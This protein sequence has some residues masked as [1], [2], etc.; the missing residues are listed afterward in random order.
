MTCGEALLALLEVYGVDTVFGIPGIH[1]M[2]LYRGLAKSK[3]R[4]ITPRHEQGAG[5]MA[6]GYA[7]VTGTPGVCFIITGPGMTNIATAMAQAFSDSIP[8]LVV[9][10]VNKTHELSLGS[11][12]LHELPSQRSLTAQFTEFS[13]TLLDP[14]ELPGVLARAF[15]VFSSRRPAPVHIEIPIDVLESNTEVTLEAWASPSKPAPD[16]QTIRQAVELLSSAERPLAILGGGT[17]D[18]AQPSRE[19]AEK[20]DMPVINTVAAKGVV[21]ASHDLCL[22]AT[23]AFKPVRELIAEADVVLAVGTEFSET[24]RYG[25][26]RPLHMTADLIRIDIDPE[27]LAR[28]H[29]PAIALHSDANLALQALA[30]EMT[31]LSSSDRISGKETVERIR[32]ELKSFQTNMIFL[33][34]LREVLPEECIIAGDSTQPVYSANSFY[35]MEQPRCWITSVTGYGT[36]GYGLPAAIGAK[37]AKPESAVACVIGDGGLLFTVSELAAAVE[38]G[39][40][41]P[42]VIWNN[43]GYGEIRTYMYELNIQP[44]GVDLYT[45]D[46]L[47]IARGFGCYAERAQSIDHLKTLLG[48]SFNKDLPTVI[49]VMEDSDFLQ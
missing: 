45:P 49:E 34:A 8:M 25:D 6:D 15:A 37:L 41:I 14:K 46:L 10:S 44:V 36:L 35:P 24:D 33:N 28:S 43:L 11:G 4:H 1:T 16:S 19:L 48:E 23:L 31:E 29:T 2:E 18:A 32:Q 3:I 20:L 26:E 38:M 39:L 21:P 5:F 22:D 42:V 17:V 12:Q 13:H 9:S 27:Q 7:R 30:S 47:A 40:S